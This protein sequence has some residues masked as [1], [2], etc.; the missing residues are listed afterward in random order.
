MLMQSYEWTRQVYIFGAQSRA[1]TLKG[2]LQF[3][4]PDIRILSFL[5]DD[6]AENALEIEGIPV[7]QLDGIEALDFSCDIFIATKGMYHEAIRKRLED[8]GA[9]RVIPVTAELDNFFRNAYMR[10]YCEQEGRSFCKIGDL[11]AE[12]AGA[13][14]YMVKSIY[15]KPLRSKYD[16]PAYEK[17]IQA[18][19][20]LT[21][22]RLFPGVLTDCTG[23]HISEKNRQYCELTALYWIW[24][25]AGE[26]ILGLSHYRR[27][28]VLPDRWQDVMWANGIDGILP[29]PTCV[30]P[31]VAGNYRER[32]DPADWDYLMRYLEENCPKDHAAAAQV[33]AGNLYSPCNMF[34]L[35]RGILD[36]LCCWMFPILDAVAE[37]GG[38]KADAYQNRY[39]GFIS[40]RLITLYFHKNREKYR[41]AYADKT[42]LA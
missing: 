39:P 37:H 4:Y 13:A 34:I 1:G 3:L 24:K 29:V 18:G 36:D 40:E 23:E 10:K 26:D 21:K 25:N 41:I 14:V 42:F 11:P 31:S 7:R 22:A 28:F 38:E 27:H 30:Q 9:T 15:D 32:H 12:R 5:V 20:A 2:Y 35:R 33:F 17:T 8:R 19:A 16:S 6:M